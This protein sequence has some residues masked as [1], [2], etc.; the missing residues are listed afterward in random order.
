MQKPDGS[1]YALFGSESG[2]NQ[3]F[4]PGETLLLWSTLYQES[5]DEALW[6]RIDAAFKYYRTWHLENRN[7]AFIP[8]HTQAYVKL[9]KIRDYPEMRDFVFR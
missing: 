9:L 2:D 5:R 1:F 6:K 4:Y 7:P 3:N 8:W